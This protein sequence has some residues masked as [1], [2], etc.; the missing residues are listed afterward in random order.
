[1]NQ[2]RGLHDV[3]GTFLADSRDSKKTCD[4]GTNGRTDGRT[5]RASYR[6]ARTLKENVFVGHSLLDN[7]VR[8]DFCCSDFSPVTSSLVQSIVHFFSA[9]N[10]FNSMRERYTFCFI[11]THFFWLSPFSG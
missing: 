11:S 1:M 9:R 2:F 8:S 7:S 10:E 5:D 4:G 3:F 6:D